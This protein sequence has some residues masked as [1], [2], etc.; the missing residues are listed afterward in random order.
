MADHGHSKYKPGEIAWGAEHHIQPVSTYAKTIVALFVLMGLTVGASFI[1]FPDLHIAGRDI[2]GTYLNNLIAMTIAVC[3]AVL[4]ILFFMHVKISTPLTRFWA[5][6]GFVW[7]TLIFFT[8]ADYAT[9][10]LDPT[11]PRPWMS[12][13]GSAMPRDR[14]GPTT[15]S[16]DPK[17]NVNIRP[18]Q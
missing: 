8:L 9:R 14:N 4:V 11:I 16:A 5:I 10:P 1:A 6:V 2:P 12:D 13:P 15:E 3:K 17:M 7:V 18:R